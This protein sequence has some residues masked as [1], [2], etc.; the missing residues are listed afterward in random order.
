[1]FSYNL[2]F[3]QNRTLRDDFIRQQTKMNEYADQAVY[4]INMVVSELRKQHSATINRD[5]IKKIS[6][7]K[8]RD[9]SAKFDMVMMKRGQLIKLLQEKNIQEIDIKSCDMKICQKYQAFHLK[10]SNRW[11]MVSNTV[12]A[13]DTTIVAAG[14]RYLI[15][16]LHS[17]ASPVQ[18]RY[19]ALGA[20]VFCA[21]DFVV[22][23]VFG[24][25]EKIELEDNTEELKRN[26]PDIRVKCNLIR[27][28]MVL[29][30]AKIKK[31]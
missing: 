14:A 7:K 28:Y 12:L 9:V 26:N 11:N 17:N 22:S 8:D 18:P 20:A 3:P 25:V 24:A 31:K 10:Y 2:L 1:M 13:T 30:A 5:T 6:M 29:E 23:G 4:G 15:K 19:L 16:H 21:I 27:D